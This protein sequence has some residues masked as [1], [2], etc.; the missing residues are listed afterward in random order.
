MECRELILSEMQLRSGRARRLARTA[1]AGGGP[2]ARASA[3]STGP[4][5]CVRLPDLVGHLPGPA[6]GLP[7]P[8]PDAGLRLPSCHARPLGQAAAGRTADLITTMDTPPLV[9]RLIYR[10]PGQQALARATLGY[11]GLRT[12]RVETFGPVIATGAAQRSRGS[13]SARATARAWG[14]APSRRSAA[15]SGS[16]PGLRRCGCSSTR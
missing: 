6:Q 10:A 13:A 4:N 16:R 11:C 9:Y 8:G 3:T 2:R 12:A 14:T 15:P 1:A 5:T 7:R